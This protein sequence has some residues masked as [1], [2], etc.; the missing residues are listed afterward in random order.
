MTDVVDRDLPVER[1]DVFDVMQL[2]RGSALESVVAGDLVEVGPGKTSGVHR[3]NRAETVLYIVSGSADVV[4]ADDVVSV[5]KGD[6]I[7]V[8]NGVHHGFRTGEDSVTFISIQSPP[9]LDAA[10]GTRDLEPL[11]Q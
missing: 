9:I 5:K 3:H 6:R 11:E 2:T 10:A 7:H 4:V 1:H 8:G